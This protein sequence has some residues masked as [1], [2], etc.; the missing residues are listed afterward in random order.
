M[1]LSTVCALNGHILVA[2]NPT[3]MLERVRALYNPR[4]IHIANF[5][6]QIVLDASKPMHLYIF[7]KLSYRMQRCQHPKPRL[8]SVARI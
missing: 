7:E 1:Y 3:S 4:L 2:R 6:L 5:F 8:Q